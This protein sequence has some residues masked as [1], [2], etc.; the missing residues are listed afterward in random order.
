MKK[1]VYYS[2]LV[3]LLLIFVVSTT[4]AFFA[5]QQGGTTST[6]ATVTSN[7]TDLL[8]FSINRDISFTVTQ[9]DFQENGQNQS[10]DATATA[11][12]TPNN[13]TGAATMN[14]YLYLNIEENPFDYS[15]TNTNELPELML[16]VFDGNN[17]L[18]TLTGLG[19]Q[20]T[21]K[22]V[23]GYD[24]TTM[25][26]PIAL[27][28]NHA[29]SASN[30]TATI[31]NWRVVITLINHDFNQNDNTGKEVSAEI[32]IQQEEMVDN[33]YYYA[34][35]ETRI[36]ANH[37]FPNETFYNNA[38]DAMNNWENIN[39]VEE[40]KPYYLKIK[41]GNA[42]AWC[43]VGDNYS[44]CINDGD[45][46]DR[47]FDCENNLESEQ[48]W[49]EP[50]DPVWSYSCEYST[51]PNAIIERY[52]EFVISEAMALANPGMVSGTYALRSAYDAESYDFYDTEDY[53]CKS[54]Y[55]NDN[56]DFCMNAS[57]NENVEL[58]NQIFDYNN[59][60]ERCH[61]DGNGYY[62]KYVCNVPGLIVSVDIREGGDLMVS[63]NGY[64]NGCVC[65]GNGNSYCGYMSLS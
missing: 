27:L 58:L 53:E 1:K 36:V 22:G 32:I 21:V 15:S 12:L 42:H 26:G 51:V 18:V 31:E 56:D 39:N 47:E 6:N 60:S 43:W 20:Q 48:H 29:I 59:H 16:Q 33:R 19:N 28:D 38:I 2:V 35:T 7:T 44:S 54:E 9:A 49:A 13:K 10:G 30:N 46:Y 5:P 52:V 50:D 45:S 25:E 17:Q 34:V 65:N 57:Y 3:V 37:A 24:I 11:T 61:I 64:D 40:V 63:D 55:Y 8:T 62:A 23:T 14:Y 4:Y 41:L